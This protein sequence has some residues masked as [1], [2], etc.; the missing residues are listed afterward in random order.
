[1]KKTLTLLRNTYGN[2]DFSIYIVFLAT[3]INRFGGFV[4]V[5]L[6]ILLKNKLGY[7]EN[8]IAN[9]IILNGVLT[10]I[11]PLIG[12][13]L[14]DRHSRKKTFIIA[15]LLGALFFTI[16]GILSR[17]QVEIIPIFIIVSSFFFS[18][19]EPI[20]N[21]LVADNTSNVHDRTRAFSLIYLGVNL[22]VAIGPLIGGR[23]LH[24]HL[25]LFF[26]FDALTT[27]I[28][29]ILV[30]KYIEDK[31]PQSQISKKRNLKFKDTDNPIKVLFKTP[32]LLSFIL[33]S[34]T[35]GILYA[36]ATFG[37]PLQLEKAYGPIIS[38]KK[39]GNLLAFNAVG[40]VLSTF[41]L[42][43]FMQKRNPINN[44]IIGQILIVLGFGMLG[45]FS[46]STPLYY[47]S[48]LIWTV[49]EVFLVTNSNV[50]IMK[51]TP[52]NFRARFGAI[53]NLTH[54]AAI[55][56]SPKLM[57]YLLTSTSPKVSWGI[58]SIIGIIGIAGFF[59][60]FIVDK[61]SNAVQP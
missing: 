12:G 25:D 54:G 16:C 28:S 45:L 52:E 48:T 10:G 29:V 47:L 44:V 7:D 1:M 33:L 38:P 6:T 35:G 60:L 8:T 51:H 11:S 36:Q 9:Y 4:F 55:V 5:F 57:A 14:G 37:L 43:N 2:L 19:C 58:L 61:R 39:M 56:L 42:T 23:L 41:T 53:Y 59:V 17:H 24:H 13:Y 50:Y 3:L 32:L 27:I 21:A 40:V 20:I 30:W 49:G 15:S 18:I 26:Y 31:L 22:G 34:L 46:Y